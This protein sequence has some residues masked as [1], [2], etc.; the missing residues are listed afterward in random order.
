MERSVCR[1]SFTVNLNEFNASFRCLFPALPQMTLI[2]GYA[3]PCLYYQVQIL[4]AFRSRQAEENVRY[5]AMLSHQR[6]HALL[7]RKKWRQLKQFLVGPRGS[8]ALRSVTSHSE[9]RNRNDRYILL[10]LCRIIPEQRWKLSPCE[11]RSRMRLKLIPNP[12]Y[13]SHIQAS[14]LR[15][16]AGKHKFR[17]TA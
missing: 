3:F 11:N 15:D 9:R 5:N 2:T 4:D 17:Q 12:N 8:W 6:G 7:I 14:R 10:I 16:N 1:S 13:D